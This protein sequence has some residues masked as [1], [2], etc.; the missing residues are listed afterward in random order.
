[1]SIL[2]DRLRSRRQSQQRTKLMYE[3][4]D[5]VIGCCG[6][7]FVGVLLGVMIVETIAG[8]GEVEYNMHNG[9]WQTLPCV[10]IPYTPVEGTW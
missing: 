3:L 1:M 4:R 6:A 2:L 9:T 7:A 8:C 10:F 5:L